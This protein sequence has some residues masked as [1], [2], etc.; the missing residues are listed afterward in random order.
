M[1]LMAWAYEARA[2]GTDLQYYWERLSSGQPMPE[3]P[4]LAAWF[5]SVPELIAHTLTG[6]IVGLVTLFLLADVIS[7]AL[8]ARVD[9]RIATA[10]IWLT[11]A[12]GPLTFMRLDLV[13]A[14]CVLVAV[15]W[16]TR[17]P[18]L[19][20]ALLGIGTMVK[21]W[22]AT[23]AAAFLGL[24]R[25][26]VRAAASGFIVVALA[27]IGATALMAGWDRVW[28]PFT[29]QGGRG[30]MVDS[31]WATWPMIV[32]AA[33]DSAYSVAVSQYQA[34]EISGGDVAFWLQVASIATIGG[35][36]VIAA[37]GGVIALR[38]VDRPDLIAWAATAIV[39]LL[40]ATNKSL[41]P[42]YVLWILAPGAVAVGL[43][44]VH[45][46]RWALAAW[47]TALALLTHLTYPLF[48]G[49]VTT[50]GPGEKRLL[51]TGV[52]A[53]RNLVLLSGTLV[54]TV[55]VW[56][57]CWRSRVESLRT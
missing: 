25:R 55:V 11:C 32:R 20:G 8:V 2:G 52:I 9:L 51:A 46:D 19:A 47:L 17:R 36:L 12:F 35:V 15:S 21:L 48:A 37:L 45:R 31:V 26:T 29:W 50:G 44:R 56:L 57:R 42:Q 22:P 10:W 5:L 1:A 39:A 18:A 40:V 3:Y 53:A 30:L 33:N 13:T 23:V 16:V 54:L 38:S 28:S 7:T 49:M 24:G 43:T 6:Y 34:F 27:S 4:A 41:S 14:L